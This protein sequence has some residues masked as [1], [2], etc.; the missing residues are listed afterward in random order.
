MDKEKE[1]GT[2]KGAAVHQWETMRIPGRKE[3]GLPLLLGR[4]P[5]NLASDLVFRTGPPSRL[6]SLGT[7]QK[8]RQQR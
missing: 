5:T 2:H 7:N 1:G 8:R 6:S 4:L 3:E